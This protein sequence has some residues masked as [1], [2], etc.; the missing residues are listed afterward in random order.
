[1]S[2]FRSFDSPELSNDKLI[3]CGFEVSCVAILAVFTYDGCMK[4]YLYI[5]GTLLFLGALIVV[6]ALN[7]R[8]QPKIE[9]FNLSARN[10]IL[11]QGASNHI[12]ING[13][14]VPNVEIALL[15]EHS[16][17]YTMVDKT[18]ADKK[19]GFSLRTVGG[20]HRQKYLVTINKSATNLNKNEGKFIRPSRGN[21][22]K[23][24]IYYP[25]Y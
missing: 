23:R 19:G 4:R 24:I 3:L 8:K 11:G 20:E 17:Y 12:I 10:T 21:T 14:T 16:K 15:S 25:A 1:M 13:R 7:A 9:I 5:L 2:R 18:Y 22:S 6:S